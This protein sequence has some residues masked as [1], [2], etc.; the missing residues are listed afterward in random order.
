[1]GRKT[2][3]RPQ[4]QKDRAKTRAIQELRR[5]NAAEPIRNRA[6]YDRNDFRRASQ[7]GAWEV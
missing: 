4:N 3:S 7:S 1:M 6:R 5:S 2:N